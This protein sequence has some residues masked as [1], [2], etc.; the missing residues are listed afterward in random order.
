M[1]SDSMR[2][3]KPI[4]LLSAYSSIRRWIS[5]CRASTIQ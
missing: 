2:P 3:M 1:A 4:W 5:N